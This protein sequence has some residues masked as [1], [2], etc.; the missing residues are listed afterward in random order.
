MGA[1]NMRWGGS[2]F[3][4]LLP[5]LVS[6][7]NALIGTNDSYSKLQNAKVSN[8]SG[9]KEE[10]SEILFYLN[11]STTPSKLPKMMRTQ[12]QAT[13]IRW[14]GTSIRSSQPY[15]VPMPNTVIGT[16]WLSHY[17]AKRKYDDQIWTGRNILQEIFVQQLTWNWCE[18]IQPSLKRK[19]KKKQ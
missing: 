5:Y 9:I 10:S 16:K 13:N 15:L 1:T 17:V 14:E 11:A 2:I 18:I 8:K 7:P 19:R 6:K 3:K 12:I 4:S